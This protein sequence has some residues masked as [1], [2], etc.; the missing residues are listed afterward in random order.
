MFGHVLLIFLAT[1]F[2]T[3]SCYCLVAGSPYTEISVNG[4]PFR[5]NS[6]IACLPGTVLFYTLSH[7]I[8]TAVLLDKYFEIAL[9]S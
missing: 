2:A 1:I 5:G 6:I 4:A 9:S 8:L 3:I 7:L